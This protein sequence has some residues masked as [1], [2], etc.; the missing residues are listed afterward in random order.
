ML[1][2]VHAYD[3]SKD[4]E[5]SWHLRGPFILSSYEA[6]LVKARRLYDSLGLTK[7]KT[8]LLSREYRSSE[9][10]VEASPRGSPL[11]AEQ[12]HSS[13]RRLTSPRTG[14]AAGEGLGGRPGG[15]Q[16]ADRARPA[17]HRRGGVR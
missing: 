9:E 6:N 7:L 4:A 8:R 2:L 11:E 1:T 16:G 13:T 5:K 3:P 17:A 14:A 12:H 15:V 10:D